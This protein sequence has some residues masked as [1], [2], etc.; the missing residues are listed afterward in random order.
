MLKKLSIILLFLYAG[1]LQALVV[2]S[3]SAPSRQ[4]ITTFPTATLNNEMLGFAAFEGGFI[5]TDAL[6]TVTFNAYFPVSYLMNLRGGLLFLDV[7]MHLSNSFTAFVST[8]T[9][10]GN[11]F[12]LTTPSSE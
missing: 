5:L 2:G 7:D 9:I 10:N 3:L 1:Y 11:G 6:T 8:G 12:S 4:A